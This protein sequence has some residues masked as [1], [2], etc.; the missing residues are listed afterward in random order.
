MIGVVILSYIM[1]HYN[2]VA[3][4]ASKDSDE[5]FDSDLLTQGEINNISQGFEPNYS[6]I[7][8]HFDASISSYYIF[9]ETDLP[10]SQSLLEKLGE[11]FL[12]I[13]KPSG[14]GLQIR[15]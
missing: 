5:S 12:I 13:K 10:I 1:E 2:A 3:I 14:K 6:G 7:Q 9:P 11:Q 15:D 8:D 4:S